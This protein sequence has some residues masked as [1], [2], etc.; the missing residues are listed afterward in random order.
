[1]TG[2]QLAALI[3]VALLGGA[4]AVVADPLRQTFLLGIYGLALTMLFFTLQAPD[5]ALS[6][7]VVST[8]GLPLIIFATL[9]KIG[10]QDRTRGDD[11][12]EHG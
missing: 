10:E 8:I 3:A 1:V 4:V 5:V 2:V 6:E 9:R 7:I 11:D 12:D